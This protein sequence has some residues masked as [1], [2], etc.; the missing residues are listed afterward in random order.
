VLIELHIMNMKFYKENVRDCFY[1]VIFC[2]PSSMKLCPSN[3]GEGP[4]N[5][6]LNVLKLN[7]S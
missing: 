6:L 1:I 2:A 5:K 7:L 3:S 4:I